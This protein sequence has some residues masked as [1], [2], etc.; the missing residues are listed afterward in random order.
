MKL[1]NVGLCSDLNPYLTLQ[2]PVVSPTGPWNPLKFLTNI[3]KIIIEMHDRDSNPHLL[4]EIFFAQPHCDFFH[5]QKKWENGKL[6]KQK[7]DT[8][9]WVN[10]PTSLKTC[11]E[12]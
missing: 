9:E 7:N 11:S 5:K 10:S 4:L 8:T 6:K 3:S 1:K 12:N 2:K